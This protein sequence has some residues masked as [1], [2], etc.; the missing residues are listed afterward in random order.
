MGVGF[1]G[2]HSIDIV[3]SFFCRHSIL[4]VAALGFSCKPEVFVQSWI[5]LRLKQAELAERIGPLAHVG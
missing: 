1:F 2:A 4:Q 5:I 3:L